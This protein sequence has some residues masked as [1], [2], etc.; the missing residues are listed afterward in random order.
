GM[1]PLITKIAALRLAPV[2]CVAWGHPVTSG[3]P[4]MDY[5]ISSEMMEPAD[6]DNHYSETLVRLPNIGVCVPKPLKSISNKT[7]ADYGLSENRTIYVFPHSLFKQLPQYD[8]IF[9]AVAKQNPRSEFIFIER[10]THSI[11][12]AHA[13]KAR[14]ADAFLQH[15][16]DAKDHIRFVP[17]QG[18]QDFLRLL[19]LSD[20]YLDSIGWSGGM[21]TL[22]ALAC[23]LPVVTMPGQFMRGRHAYGCLKRIGINETIAQST[24]D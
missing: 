7:R 4:T 12:A 17:Q 21:T 5:Y 14:V 20:V 11:E 3:V 15:D 1:N 24:E 16:L 8:W 22:E 13:F 9:P 10:E 18:L 19:S 23:M 2:Q 6:G